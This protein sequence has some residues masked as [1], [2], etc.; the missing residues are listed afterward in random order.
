[1][2][3]PADRPLPPL[4]LTEWEPAKTTLHLWVQ[5]VGKVKLA[6]SPPRNHWWHVPLYVD[7]RG[8]TTRRL[9]APSGITFEIVF[10]FIDH[11]LQVFTSEGGDASFELH[12]GLSVAEFDE[13]LHWTLA[14]L[15]V[16]VQILEQPFGVPITTPFR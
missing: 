15:D 7:V 4:P 9:H 13:Q 2:S 5:I 14:T 3:E 11:R 1:M 16:D 10:D 8:M 6:T 12:D